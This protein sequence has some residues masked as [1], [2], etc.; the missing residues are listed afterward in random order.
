MDSGCRKHFKD[1]KQ[2][3]QIVVI[4]FASGSPGVSPSEV[5]AHLCRVPFLFLTLVHKLADSLAEPVPLHE[6]DAAITG[7]GRYYVSQHFAK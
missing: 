1:Y 3:Q 2:M 4:S 7:S 5:A 6:G